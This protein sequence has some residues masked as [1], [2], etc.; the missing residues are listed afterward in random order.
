ML[1]KNPPHPILRCKCFGKGAPVSCGVCERP[2]ACPTQSSS[3]TASFL[4]SY[5]SAYPRWS[6][7]HVQAHPW[8]P[9]ISPGVHLRPSN[10]Y[11][12]MR[13]AYTFHQQRFYTHRHQHAFSIRAM[14]FWN[15]LPALIASASPVQSFMRLLDANWQ[16]LVT[17]EPLLPASSHGPFRL[18]TWPQLETHTHMTLFIDHPTLSSTAVFT[19]H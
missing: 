19:A 12:A 1:F 4:L 3:P 16:S 6:N 18:Y 11:R 10:S 9:G 2:S 13:P 7:I 14:P 15:K 8:I 5:P 17:E